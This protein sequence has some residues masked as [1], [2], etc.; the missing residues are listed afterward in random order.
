MTQSNK[1]VLFVVLA[2]ITGIGIIVVLATGLVL[3]KF[4]R[5]HSDPPQ[6]LSGKQETLEVTYIHWA[7][8]CANYLDVKHFQDHP[9]E[10]VKDTDCFFIEPAN[11]NIVV[12]E[13]FENED[14][15]DC[16]LRLTGQFYLDQGIPESYVSP[17]P[18]TP[19]RARVFRYEAFE[20][21][22]KGK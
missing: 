9:N 16:N 11:A 17:T 10:E 7:C 8:A 6:Q 4:S 19:E 14:Y 21:V 12:P 2:F 20:L 3:Y 15:W 5:Q 1:V 18:E 13:S 22:P